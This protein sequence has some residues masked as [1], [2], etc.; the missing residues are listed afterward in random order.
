MAVE[1]GAT[2]QPGGGY[3]VDSLGQSPRSPSPQ[4]T[5]P[6]ARVCALGPAFVG[7]QTR[8]SPTTKKPPTKRS[9]ASR[10][11]LESRYLPPGRGSV[12]PK[13]W[14]TAGFWSGDGLAG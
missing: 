10:T 12:P 11:E 2:W 14:I 8:G 3:L 6:V 5:H 7:S 13:D 4:I 9:G 1:A